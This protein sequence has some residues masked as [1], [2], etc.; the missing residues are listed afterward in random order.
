MK[1]KSVTLCAALLSM[2]ATA[3][4]E[5]ATLRF[6]GPVSPLTFDP[7]ATNDFTTTALFRQVYDSLIGMTPDMKPVPGHLL[8]AAGRSQLALQAARWRDIP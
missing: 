8:G 1:A 7:H 2:A 6:A 4:V 5:A 3:G